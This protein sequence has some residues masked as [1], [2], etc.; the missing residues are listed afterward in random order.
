MPPALRKGGLSMTSL[1]AKYNEVFGFSVGEQ[2][3]GRIEKKG[4]FFED[5]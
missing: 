1:P 2:E 5:R 3:E 4:I